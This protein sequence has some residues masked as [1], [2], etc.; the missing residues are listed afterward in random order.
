ML[1]VIKE[2]RPFLSLL[3]I[4]LLLCIIQQIKYEHQWLLYFGN[5]LVARTKLTGKYL[6]I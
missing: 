6:V 2:G 3:C 1:H 4:A 5:L